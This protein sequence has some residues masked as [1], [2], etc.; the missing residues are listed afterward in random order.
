M[1]SEKRETSV[2][3]RSAR[4]DDVDAVNRLAGQLGYPSDSDATR[5]RLVRLMNAAHDDVFVATEGADVVGWIQVGVHVCLEST[6]FAEIFGL[7]VDESRRGRGVGRALVGRA[8]VWAR[9]RG[10]AK[11]RVRSNVVREAT[12]R[13]YEA[14]GFSGSKRQTVFDKTI[15]Y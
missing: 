12:H 13:F 4:I 10:I 8:E 1:K 2:E 15:R 6:S 11:L 5:E 3:I 9:E 7:V 14:L